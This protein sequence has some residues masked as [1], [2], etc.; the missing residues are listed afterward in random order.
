MI[1]QKKKSKKTHPPKYKGLA[2][3]QEQDAVGKQGLKK[4]RKS[5]N[6]Y[7]SRRVAL[8]DKTELCSTGVKC[9]AAYIK[10]DK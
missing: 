5:K 4:S 3:L 9:M 1:K 7:K 2:R 6:T 8:H 10:G